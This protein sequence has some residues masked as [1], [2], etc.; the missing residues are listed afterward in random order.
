MPRRRLVSMNVSRSIA[1]M[2]APSTLAISCGSTGSPV[3]ISMKVFNRASARVTTSIAVPDVSMVA[4]AHPGG[5][6][7]ALRAS[8]K[9]ASV[10]S[11][12]HVAGEGGAVEILGLALVVGM[13]G[14]HRPARDLG[15]EL[16]VGEQRLGDRVANLLRHGRV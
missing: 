13:D 10:V 5:S 4:A 16:R 2:T 7:G 3:C 11:G 12:E 14:R 1:A 6:P 9:R 8:A 15:G